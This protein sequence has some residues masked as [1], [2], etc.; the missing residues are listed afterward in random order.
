MKK[1]SPALF[2]III[3]CF[4]LPFVG[5]SCGGTEVLQLNG[6]DLVKG[7]TQDGQG[8]DP[9]PLAIISLLAAIAGLAVGFM[10]KKSA[11]LIAAIMGA[12]GFISNIIMKSTIDGNAAEQGLETNW[13]AG[14]YLSLLLFLAA[15]LFNIY[16]MKKG[17]AQEFPGGPIDPEV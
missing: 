9:N 6:L 10:E 17:E 16:T 11:N 5:V 13:H 14:Y 7:F 4:L 8:I 12:V 2:G 15:V 1:L 3:I